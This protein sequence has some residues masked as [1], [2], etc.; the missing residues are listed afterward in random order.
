MQSCSTAPAGICYAAHGAITELPLGSTVTESWTYNQRLEPTDLK[1]TGSAGL[2]LELSYGYSPTGNNGN[3]TSA[4]IAFPNGS[5]GTVTINQ[6][7]SYDALN[8]L[9]VAEEN[10]ANPSSPNC[11]DPGAVWCQRY[12]YTASGNRSVPQSVGQGVSPQT[13]AR[14]QSHHKPDQRFRVGLRQRR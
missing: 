4:S 9:L 7:F 2:L 10:P 13:R 5:G 14:V 8:R 3:V 1:A 11:A 12:S 6:A